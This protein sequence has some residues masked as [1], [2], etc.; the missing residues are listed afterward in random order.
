MKSIDIAKKLFWVIVA[1]FAFM[2]YFSDFRSF[3]ETIIGIYGLAFVDGAITVAV[4]LVIFFYIESIREE[5]LQSKIKRAEP[6]ISQYDQRFKHVEARLFYPPEIKY[7]KGDRDPKRNNPRL[8]LILLTDLK[9]AYWVGKYAWNLIYEDKIR[10]HSEDKQNIEEW[11]KR[12]GYTLIPRDA[13]ESNLLEPYHQAE[14][15][16]KKRI[17]K[18]GA[19]IIFKTQYR[20]KLI[21]GFFSNQIFTPKKT[22]FSNGSR[23]T[24]SWAPDTLDSGDPYVKG[25]LNGYD[26]HESVWSWSIPLDAPLGLYRIYMRVHNHFTAKSRPTIAQIDDTFAVVHGDEE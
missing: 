5:L 14:I 15:L 21:N 2:E 3:L 1:F 8:K 6:I 12:E 7:E 4:L 26:Y 23:R 10:W 17:F 9:K 24:S 13:T 20:G 18:R 22:A 16:N 25:K 19:A 11:C